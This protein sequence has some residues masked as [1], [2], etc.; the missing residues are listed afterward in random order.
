MYRNRITVTAV[1]ACLSLILLAA[2]GKVNV[3]A[4]TPTTS[5]DSAAVNNG[6]KSLVVMRVSTPWGSPAETRWLHLE[7]GE[8]VKVTSQFAAGT[9]QKAKEFD[10]VTLPGGTYA[11]ASVM[12]SDGTK[13]VWPGAFDLDASKSEITKLGQVQLTENKQDDGSVNTVSALR[14]RALEADGKTPLIASFTVTPGK[15]V[16]LG[17]MTI[18]FD[19]KGK[20]QLPGYY[21][22]GS[23]AWSIDEKPFERAKLTLAGEDVGLAEKMARQSIKRGTLARRL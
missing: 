10:M 14:S 21:P 20:K 2:C 4:I 8:L 11:L 22:A 9:Q 16:Y 5:I 17:N 23:V 3:P 1:C 13:G 6:E 19:I 18:K 7:T 12:Y 15:V